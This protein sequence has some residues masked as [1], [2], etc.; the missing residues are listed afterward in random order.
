[1]SNVL[2]G[3]RDFEVTYEYQDRNAFVHLEITNWNKSVLRRLQ[4]VFELIR[5]RFRQDGEPTFFA[6]TQDPKAKKLWHLIMPWDE[7]QEFKP[8]GQPTAW[9]GAWHTE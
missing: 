3:D 4:Y 2:Y 6:T 9:L 8:V 1:M 7:I 5:L